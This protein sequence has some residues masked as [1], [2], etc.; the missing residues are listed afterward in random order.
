MTEF[1][2]RAY[3]MLCVWVLLCIVMTLSAHMVGFVASVYIYFVL[4]FMAA[5][6]TIGDHYQR[7][8]ESK[9]LQI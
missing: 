3:K 8:E 4:L 2:R 6:K 1:L 7:L 5:I 9:H